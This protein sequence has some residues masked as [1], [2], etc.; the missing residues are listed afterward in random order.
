MEVSIGEHNHAVRLARAI[1]EVAPEFEDMIQE[2]DFV[3]S[4]LNQIENDESL[5]EEQ[6]AEIERMG[7]RYEIIA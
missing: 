4:V 7:D 1:D 2:A 6:M 5:T 3:E